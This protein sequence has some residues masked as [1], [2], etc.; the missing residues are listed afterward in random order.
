MIRLYPKI[1]MDFGAGFVDVSDDVIAPPKVEWGIRSSN[2]TD[3][4]AEPGPLQLELD[5]S[6]WNSGGKRGYYSPG[7]P[8]ARVGFDI[9][10][11]V[12][13]ELGHPTFGAPVKW[14]GTVKSITAAP[15]T[16]R[17]AT[18]VEAVDWME[19]AALAKLSGLQV[20]TD[21]Q[22]DQA[23]ALLV[24][25]VD[26]QPPNGI[27][28]GTGS[29]V[30]PFVFDNAQDEKSTV[31]SELLKLALSELG[32]VTDQAGV[33][34]FDGRRR[35]AGG[36]SVRFALHEDEQIVAM[37]VAN[38]RDDIVNRVQVSVNPRR[39]DADNETVLFRLGSAIQIPRYTSVEIDC[40]YRDPDQ[41]A[42]RVGGMDMQEPEPGVDYEFNTQEQGTGADVTEQLSIES[43]F[44]GNKARLV[45]TNSGPGD[46]WIPAGGLELR[47]RRLS[48]FEPILSDQRDEAS[49]A[50]FGETSLNYDMPYQSSIENAAD[51]GKFLLSLRSDP[52]TRVESVTFVANWDDETAE[53]ALNLRVL[54]IISITSPTLGLVDQPFYAMGF[55]H[56]VGLNGVVPVTVYVWPVDTNQYWILEEEGRSELDESTVLGYGLFAPGWILDSSELGT[57]TFAG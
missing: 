6:K 44:S 37:T 57:D 13:Y 21:I 36:G 3:R 33:V 7:H 42:Q 24:A 27:W 22:S 35:L 54:D 29:D 31:T 51:L 38:D 5:N 40:P 49:I 30:Y 2:P 8:D 16:A 17:P 56:Q 50:A 4:V 55:A 14:I 23:F 19:E 32:V 39:R 20:Q 12:L 48:V 18:R 9:G 34:V 41:Q 45:I 46:G 28:Y 47:G 11:P 15:G 26:R 52:R 10:T 25:A 43:T 53:Q 1:K